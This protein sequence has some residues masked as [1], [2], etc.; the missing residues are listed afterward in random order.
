MVVRTLFAIL[1]TFCSLCSTALSADPPGTPNAEV[2]KQVSVFEGV[3]KV[4]PKF[5]YKYYIVGFAE[6]QHFALFG[7]DKLKDI[8][9]GSTIHVEGRL[10][11]RFHPGGNER[12]ASPFPRT[13]Y[14]Y[15]EVESVKVLREPEKAA[16]SPGPPV[17]PRLRGTEP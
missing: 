1:L 2:K 3:L 7:E 14:V 6:G 13:W 8:K 5:L 11:T 4:H 12:N 15:M 16:P 17:S 10:G 9:P